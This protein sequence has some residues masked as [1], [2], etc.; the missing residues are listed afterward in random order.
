MIVLDTSVLSLAYR[1]P[2]RR[3][4]PPPVVARLRALIERDAA[5]GLPGIVL[6]E[7]LSGIREEG[8]ARRVA[9]QLEGF[10]LLLATRADHVEASTLHSRCRAAGISAGTVD[11][12]IAAQTIRAGGELFTLDRD[13]VH[14]AGHS[15]L[16]LFDEGRL[17]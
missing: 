14:L 7:L 2:A 11:C 9:D 10:P 4:A 8:A 5:F 1:R 3:Q 12:L 16:Q 6:Q 17:D 13:F 15:R